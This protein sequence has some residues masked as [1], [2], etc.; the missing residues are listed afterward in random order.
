MMIITD[1][2]LSL[3]SIATGVSQP[4]LRTPAVLHLP[5]RSACLFRATL[6]AMRKRTAKGTDVTVGVNEVNVGVNE[7]N[8][9]PLLT[10]QST[11]QSPFAVTP[12]RV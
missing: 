1:V 11:R 4:C 10:R 9:G 5:L 8:V 12:F 6:V 7:V 2:Q 3:C